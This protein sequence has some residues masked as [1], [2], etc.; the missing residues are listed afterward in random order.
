M[1]NPTIIWIEVRLSFG[2]ACGVGLTGAV[3][4]PPEG[5][6]LWGMVCS[7]IVGV[8]GIVVVVVCTAPK[9]SVVRILGVI[10]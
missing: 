5:E 2:P 6:V 7:A 10:C 4:T 3:V 1:H 8:V 9:A